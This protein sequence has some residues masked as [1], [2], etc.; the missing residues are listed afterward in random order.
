M[1]TAYEN[2][3][4]F[5]EGADRYLDQ[6][7][8]Q[9]VRAIVNILTEAPFF[10]RTDDVD[11]FAY[12]RN[13]QDDFEQFLTHYC[14]W[15]LYVD[16]RVAR[17]VKPREYN[18][19][20]RPSQRDLF[21]LTRRD[22]CVVYLLLIEYYE[23]LLRDLN[24]TYDDEGALRFLLADFVQYCIERFTEELGDERPD[25]RVVLD[26]CR[27]MFPKLIRY[28]FIEQVEREDAGRDEQLPAGMREHVMYEFLPGIH[29]YRPDVLTFKEIIKLY[30][31]AKPDRDEDEELEDAGVQEANA[32]VGAGVVSGQ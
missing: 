26:A 10:Y 4:H 19:A 31:D 9:Y 16:R 13:H 30:T 14:G 28:R 25:D 23:K 11:L 17:V 29:C 27:T 2:P 5:V 21:D 20:L 24:L 32:E 18:D 6:L 12:L 3:E 15:E 8:I 22:E 1:E 7:N